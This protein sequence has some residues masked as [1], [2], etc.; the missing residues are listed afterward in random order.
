MP[1]KSEPELF[2][3]HCVDTE[4]PLDESITATFSRLKEIYGISADPSVETLEEIQRQQAS[5]VPKE[6]AETVAK[7]FSP[8]NLSYLRNWIELDEMLRHYF[9]SDFR[10]RF[11]DD[12]GNLFATSWFVMDHEEYQSNPRNK[13]IGQGEIH[14]KYADLLHSHPDVED[15]IQYHFHPSSISGNPVGAATSYANSMP[16]ILS[17]LAMRL[18]TFDWFPTCFRP[19]FHSIRPDSHLFLEQWFPFDFSN[20][21]HEDLE[22]QPDLAGG[23]FGDWRRAPRT[24]QG[25]RPSLSDHQKAGS[26]ERVIFR[27]LNVGSRLRELKRNHIIEAFDE[28]NTNGSAILAFT[29]HD[30]RDIR[31]DVSRVVQEVRDVQKK[32]SRV[33]VRFASASEAARRHLN[34]GP[35]RP[36]LNVALMDNL[37]TVQT[38]M[39]KLHSHQPF[40]AIKTRD[41]VFLHDNFDEFD[42]KGS[43]CFTFDS[44]TIEL[45]SVDTIGVA[46]VG[47]N[48][49][50]ATAI[51]S[52]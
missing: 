45:E 35:E 38:D 14:K 42:S 27:C 48:G 49:K 3:V 36:D 18:I 31:S 50:P 22:N 16:R 8:E 9:S 51:V 19:G 24:W 25:Y 40:L 11:K 28:A 41:G 32:F 5:F 30:F 43:F 47:K 37:L 34:L 4:G 52:L 17:D 33:R 39:T 23:R 6:I 1:K 26:L 44:Q 10:S 29:N 7:T 46:V 12:F 13:T 21:S 15:E 20:Q 2:V